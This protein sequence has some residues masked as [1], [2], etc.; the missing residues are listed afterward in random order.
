MRG[1]PSSAAAAA[2]SKTKTK[3]VVDAGAR[4]P[5]VGRNWFKRDAR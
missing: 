2:M 4:A 1:Q 3:I 5:G